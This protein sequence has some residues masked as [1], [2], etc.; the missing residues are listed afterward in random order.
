MLTCISHLP[1]SS[2]HKSENWVKTVFVAVVVLRGYKRRHTDLMILL[3]D[4]I[5]FQM[6]TS[7]RV[8]SGFCKNR[9]V[10]LCWRECGESGLPC[11]SA[12]S[13]PLTMCQLCGQPAVLSGNYALGI[14][15]AVSKIFYSMVLYSINSKD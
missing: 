7:S 4:R 8:S 9:C 10:L 5:M 12:D 13:A 6:I 11:Q 14:S 15:A 3:A 1:R 2:A